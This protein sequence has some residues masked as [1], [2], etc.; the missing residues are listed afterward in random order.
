E[1]IDDAAAEGWLVHL[2]YVAEEDLPALY[3][4]AALFIYPS[5][6]EGFGLPPIEAMASG[7]PVVV[8]NR[9]CLPEVCGDAVRYV[10]PDDDNDFLTAIEE[11]LFNSDW[12]KQAIDRGL[13]R[14]AGY[15]WGRCVRDTV[16]VYNFVNS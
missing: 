7:V 14:A 6:Y 5:I 2:G 1:Q 12:R 9:S 4:G 15:T 8:A 11:S 16:A 13:K 3:A 10:D